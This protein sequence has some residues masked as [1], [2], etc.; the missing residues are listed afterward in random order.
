MTLKIKITVYYKDE[1][2]FETSVE[3]TDRIAVLADEDGVSVRSDGNRLELPSNNSEEES[4]I[5][6]FSGQM[7]LFDNNPWNMKI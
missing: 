3:A 6:D 1:V 7:T 2:P 4:K 5:S